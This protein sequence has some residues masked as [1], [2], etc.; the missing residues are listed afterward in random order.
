MQVPSVAS[1]SPIT[2]GTPLNERAAIDRD[3]KRE[4]ALREARQQEVQSA[5]PPGVGGRLDRKA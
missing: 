5:L 3:R 2:T 4:D 1:V